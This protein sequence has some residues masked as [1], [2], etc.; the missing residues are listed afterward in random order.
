MGAGEAH[1]EAQEERASDPTEETQIHHGRSL[2]G[3]KQKDD[4]ALSK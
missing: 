3:Q 4:S 2:L 1:H